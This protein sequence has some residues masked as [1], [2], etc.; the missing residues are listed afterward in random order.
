MADNINTQFCRELLK[1]SIEDAKKQG[2]RIPRIYCMKLGGDYIE[3]RGP[4]N[5]QD[6]IIWEGQAD[7]CFDAK[8][9][10]IAVL[11]ERAGGT[12]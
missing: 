8:A 10:A 6:D 3:V 7:N 9:Q 12:V 2:I 4:V 11:I 1:I 5:G